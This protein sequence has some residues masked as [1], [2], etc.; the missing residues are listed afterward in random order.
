MWSQDCDYPEKNVLNVEDEVAESVARQIQ[1][2]LTSQH[3][4]V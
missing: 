3:S 2:R 4:S 1:L